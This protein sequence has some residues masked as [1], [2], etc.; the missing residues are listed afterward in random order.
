MGQ[1]DTFRGLCLCGAVG[2][3]FDAPTLWCAHCHC[4]LCQRAHGAAFVTW[5]GAAAARTRILDPKEHLCW[6]ASSADSERG[7]CDRCGSTLF[8]RSERWP[9]ELHIVLANV[10]GEIDREPTSHVHWDTHAAWCA[11]NDDLEKRPGVG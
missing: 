3:H 8:F 6:Y 7:F 9:G 11:V 5:V 10:A 1:Q 4:T 2:V